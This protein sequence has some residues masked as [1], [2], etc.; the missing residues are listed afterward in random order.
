MQRVLSNSSAFLATATVSILSPG[1][2]PCVAVEN[3]NCHS[4]MNDYEFNK[5]AGFARKFVG[6]FTN[7]PATSRGARESP[8]SSLTFTHAPGGSV[9]QTSRGRRNISLNCFQ[10]ASS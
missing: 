1:R 2:D 5:S 3:S 7:Q 4:V 10:V 9:L 8:Q 6:N